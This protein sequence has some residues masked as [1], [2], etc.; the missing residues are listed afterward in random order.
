[1]IKRPSIYCFSQLLANAVLIGHNL[2]LSHLKMY[3][4]MTEVLRF[5]R[6]VGI[7]KEAL[8]TH[9]NDPIQRKREQSLCLGISLSTQKLAFCRMMNTIK[10]KLSREQHTE[11]SLPI[12]T[13]KT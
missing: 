2:I 11:V 13:V 8:I 3:L 10:K 12:P 9:T 1:M 7:R 4:Y 5:L 6:G